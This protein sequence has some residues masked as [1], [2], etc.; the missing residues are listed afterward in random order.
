MQGVFKGARKGE[1]SRGIPK[2]EGK[3]A[4]GAGRPLLLGVDFAGGGNCGRGGRRQ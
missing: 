1:R 4:A 2:A 3:A